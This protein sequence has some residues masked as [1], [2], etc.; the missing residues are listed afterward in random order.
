MLLII[1]VIDL[2]GSH[3]VRATDGSFQREKT[4]FDDPVKMAKL[5][6]I[7]NARALHVHGHD[8]GDRC[9][10]KVLRSLCEAVDIPIQLHGGFA[11]LNDVRSA[12]DTGVYRVIID[13][14]SAEERTLFSD[15]L[16]EFG[17]SKTAA[18]IRAF[19]GV[20]KGAS[21]LRADELCKD[22]EREGCRRIFY[23][24]LSE[25]GELTDVNVEAFRLLGAKLKKTRITVADG[26]TGFEQ[27][28]QFQEMSGIGIDSVVIGRALYENRFPCQ[29]FWC[30]NYKDEVDLSR[31]STAQLSG[32]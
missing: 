17:P 16:A 10:R 32:S 2:L 31:V 7:Q 5:W 1:P 24:D 19:Q 3:C 22:L 26:I 12:L 30:W 18:G 6:R 23:S 20:L 25:N 9:R 14:T 27:L 29:Q 4:F 15:A 21:E 8:E 28:M 13:I 11:E